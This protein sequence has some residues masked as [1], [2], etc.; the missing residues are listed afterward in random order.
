M[1]R[2]NLFT[3]HDLKAWLNEPYQTPPEV[4]RV[5]QLALPLPG[6]RKPN[7]RRAK[8]TSSQNLADPVHQ[9]T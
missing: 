3:Y 8:G 5:G 1:L 9:A 2:L 6:L 7:A 4:P